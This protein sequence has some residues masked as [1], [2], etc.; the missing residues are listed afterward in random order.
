LPAELVFAPTAWFSCLVLVLEA[1]KFPKLTR[2]VVASLVLLYA[3]AASITR[4]LL[5]GALYLIH[6]GVVFEFAFTAF[7]L[8][9]HLTGLSNVECFIVGG[10]YKKAASYAAEDVAFVFAIMY[11]SRFASRAEAVSEVWETAKDVPGREFIISRI[12]LVRGKSLHVRVRDEN[13]T[14]I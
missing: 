3:Y 6:T 1:R 8:V 7:A 2:H 4:T 12:R 13:T 9:V 5:G 10:A 14:T 11:L